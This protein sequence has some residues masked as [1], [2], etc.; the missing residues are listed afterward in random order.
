MTNILADARLALRSWRKSP[1]FA[2]IAIVSI[3]LGIGA[4][5]AIFTLV[6]QVLLRT[7][8]VRDPHELVQVTYTGSRYG[9]NWGD[10][11]ELSYPMY[12]EIRDHNDVFSGTFARFGYPFHIG[13]AG[14]TERVAGEIVSGTYFPVL[15][16]GAALGR[17]LGEDD[18][19]TP[20]AHPV[21]VLSH[22]F[23]TSRFGS[24]PGVLNSTITI[25][26]YP[27][28]IVGVARRGFDGVEVGRQT[29]VF[30]PMMMKAQVTPNW[31]ALDERLWRWVRVF[32]R[33]RPGVNAEQ[34]RAALEPYFRTLLE[35]DLSDPGFANA[36]ASVR[37][38]YLENQLRLPD[39]SQGRSGLRRNLTTPLWVLMATAAGVLLIACANIANLLLARGAARQ[40]EIAVRLALGA[41]RRRIVG[42]LLVESM[43]LAA[44]GAVLGVAISA[45]TA[46]IVLG[47]FVS[48]DVPQPVSTAPDWRILAFTCAVATLT[49]LL[50]GI[51]PAFQS[52]RTNVAPT[53]KD[54]TTSVLGGQTRLRKVLVASQIAVSLLLLIGAALFIR[55][56]DNLLAVDIGFQTSRLL[57]F[58]MDPSLSGY[59]PDR[60]RQFAVSLV[61][62]LNAAP[63]VEAAGI[64]TMRLLEGN[65]WST[66]ISVE[67]YQAKPD[68]NMTQWANSVS[69]GYFK[70]MGIP[71]LMGR[72]F[73]QRDAITKAPPSGTP[74]YRVAIVNE[75]FAQHY[76][77]TGNPIGRRIG[78]GGDP[79]TPT[80]I[81]IVGVVRDSKY[82]NVRD[83]IQ[84]QV[85]FPFFEN[86]RPS[87]FTVYLRTSRPA[88][89][90]FNV[91]RQTVQQ[92]D[93]NLPVH[94]TRT[95]ERQVELS[96]SRER[97][98]ATMSAAFGSL[99]TLLSVI[100]LYA[101]MSYTVSR[102]TREIG[103]RV[104]LGASAGSISWLVI[105]E[106][107]II[108]AAG[109]AVALPAAWWLGRFVST[110]LYGVTPG[111]PMTILGAVLLLLTVALLAGTIPS[112]RAARLDP[113]TALRHD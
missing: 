42:Q 98:V 73:N 53:L 52:T 112:A 46:P 6:D 40:R 2:A 75:R 109:M 43:M 102:R 97:L 103:V 74:D 37:K 107:L 51:G 12:R 81:E 23:W 80:P 113:T 7:L 65:Q 34:A 16:V 86:S 76:F 106:V 67:G 26:G 4:N 28:T 39:A 84:R 3:G 48:P 55:T 31:N 96:L 79:N 104:A 94:S 68:E 30:V 57:S 17:T 54:Q 90:M 111:D 88:D 64:A 38:Q 62:R 108:A 41:T 11:S 95:V 35:R 83:Q 21:I 78:F 10:N 70:A 15:G 110:Q 59:S 69:P 9:N 47:F 58:G 85:F 19:R 56:L 14:R 36:S 72:D 8:P 61:E 91:A 60:S 1:A 71:V 89:T 33:L 25:N 100:G 99:A 101:V 27:Y 105:R 63:G 50:F 24:D 20:G 18:D 29:Q 49:G 66:S 45:A 44:A 77:G 82:T 5:A 22:N 32:A 92:I 87:A 13:T 93:P